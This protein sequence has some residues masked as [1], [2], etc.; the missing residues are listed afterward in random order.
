MNLLNSAIPPLTVRSERLQAVIFDWAGTTVDFG[1]LAPARTIQRLFEDYAVDLSEHDA[2]RHMGLSKKE[3]I[4]GILSMAH[5]RDSWMRVYGSAPA[6]ADIERIYA[7]FVP[8]QL[9]CLRDYA[10]LIPGVVETVAALRARGLKIGSNSGYTR[11][12]VD[13][14]LEL[15]AHE[16]YVPDCSVTPDEAGAGRPHPYMMYECAIRLQV[17][18]MGAIVKVGDTPAD[19]EEGLNA[20]SWAIGV[21]GTGNRIGMSHAEFESLPLPE[22]EFLLSKAREELRKAGAHYVI[23]SLAELMNV[24]EDIDSRLCT[25]PVVI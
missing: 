18:P 22:R 24:I 11:E 20:G 17:Y 12:M 8:M 16:G 6:E 19:V 23:D 15:A 21:A 4:R 5:L 9:S 7:D 3:H 13:V 1:C 25:A 2:R 14:L 10:A